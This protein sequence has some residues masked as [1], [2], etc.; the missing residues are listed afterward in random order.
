M[1]ALYIVVSAIGSG[2]ARIYL[3]RDMNKLTDAERLCP[4]CGSTTTL[5]VTMGIPHLSVGGA[6]L[7]GRRVPL[8]AV[9]ISRVEFTR[10]RACKVGMYATRTEGLGE[11]LRNTSGTAATGEE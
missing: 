8:P 7:L 6:E 11:A 5:R 4:R 2:S 1:A 9:R 10:C 3:G